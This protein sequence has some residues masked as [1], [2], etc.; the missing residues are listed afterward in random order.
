[1]SQSTFAEIAVVLRETDS[2]AVL[3]RPVKAGDELLHGAVRL[4]VTQNI[5]AGHKIALH[6]IPDGAPVRKYSQIIGVA[7][8]RIAPGEHVHTHNLVMKDFGRDYEFCADSRPVAYYATH[9]QIDPR[10]ELWRLRW[11]QRHHGEPGVGCRF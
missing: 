2:V 1:M 10:R 11:K 5:G 7:Q 3:K 8:G 9:Q 6:E 4:R